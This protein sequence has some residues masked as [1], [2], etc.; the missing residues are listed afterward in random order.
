MWSDTRKW[1]LLNNFKLKSIEKKFFYGDSCEQGGTQPLR[2]LSKVVLRGRHIADSPSTPVIRYPSR[3]FT[4]G[5]LCASSWKCR[6][7]KENKRSTDNGFGSRLCWWCCIVARHCCGPVIVS[8]FC[9]RSQGGVSRVRETPSTIVRHVRDYSEERSFDDKTG[10][11]RHPSSPPTLV[12]SQCAGARKGR[13][14]VIAKLAIETFMT[15][16]SPGLARPRAKVNVNRLSTPES[17]RFVRYFFNPPSAGRHLL[18]ED[19][20]S[21]TASSRN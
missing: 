20:L 3:F 7:W 5:A 9:D 13:K 21:Q 6:G 18:L 15:L 14:V 17:I 8:L 4:A 19:R 2:S 11:E 1:Y 10:F 12:L 16:T